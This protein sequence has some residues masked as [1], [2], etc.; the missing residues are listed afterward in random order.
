M[1]SITFNREE[2]YKE[3]WSKPMTQIAEEHN[4]N[5]YQLTKA[6][7]ELNIPRPRS[8]YWSKL[9]NGIKVKQKPLTDFEK[10]S[11]TL[12]IRSVN[13]TD[14]GNLLPKNYQPLE[15]KDQLRNAHSLI[16]DTYNFLKH[17]G[18]ER[19]ATDEYGRLGTHR[20]G[21]ANVKASLKSLN[22]AMRILDAIFKEA[23]RQGFKVGTL[24][25]YDRNATFIQVDQDKVY[26]SIMEEGKQNRTRINDKSSRWPEYEYDRCTTGKLKL[27]LATNVY[28]YSSKS[29]SDTKTKTLE[30]R[31]DEVFPLLLQIAEEER[32]DRL[33]SE[34][35][36]RKAEIARKIREQQEREYQAE[37]EKRSQLEEQA[38]LF[39]NSAYIYQYIQEVESQVNSNDFTDE[40]T[41]KFEEWKKWALQ[42]AD[43]LN[44]VK[45][46]LDSF[47]SEAENA[48]SQNPSVHDS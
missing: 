16:N 9:R 24:T 22:R 8:G 5:I 30:E 29:L 44:P 31:I 36:A 4:I 35:R 42:H 47:L 25:K 38:T 10:D 41:Q 23:E 19:F 11:Y 3:L 32:I 14:L 43:R 1:K 28:S 33:E 40:Q 37:M 6:C 2:L 13:E 12:V 15:V 17:K 27:Q 48:S 39:T 18:K 34:E 21:Y 20:S 45:Q 7:D 46:K 26:I